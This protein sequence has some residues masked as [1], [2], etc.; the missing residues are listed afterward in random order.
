MPGYVSALFISLRDG[1]A[2]ERE[3]EGRLLGRLLA[4]LWYVI[5]GGA[6]ILLALD[7]WLFWPN[8]IT[9]LP[10]DNVPGTPFA[11]IDI[12]VFPMLFSSGFTALRPVYRTARES[13]RILV[14]AIRSAAAAR[15]AVVAPEVGG[16]EG[17]G[18]ADAAVPGDFEGAATIAPLAHP[19]GSTGAADA[20][21]LIGA[22]A[23]LAWCGGA[24]Y[25]TTTLLSDPYPT[26][27]PQLVSLAELP[28]IVALGGLVLG[29]WSLVAWRE[30]RRARRGMIAEVDG[31]GVTV[32]VAARRGRLRHLRWSDARSFARV[33]YVDNHAQ[34]HIAYIMMTDVG[35][36]LWDEPPA[37]RYLSPVEIARAQALRDAARRLA[38]LVEQRTGLPL[39]DLSAIAQVGRIDPLSAGQPQQ[40]LF[41]QAIEIARGL[42]DRT[43]ARKLWLGTHPGAGE[44]P[45]KE[46]SRI[47]RPG[48]FLR[49][50]TPQR[51]EIVRYALALLPYFPTP[52]QTTPDPLERQRNELRAYRMQRE[53]GILLTAL[54]AI[55]LISA[56]CYGVSHWYMPSQLNPLP[57]RIRAQTPLYIAPFTAHQN[58]WPT[59][60][61]A[62][63]D[64]RSARFTARGYELATTDPEQASAAWTQFT[65]VGDGAVRVTLR[66]HPGDYDSAGM[67]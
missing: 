24:L 48:I 54:L 43:L 35:D 40:N 50:T 29:A 11:L 55:G 62:G 6:M 7:C 58:D 28:A 65:T 64:T 5:V 46:V 57:V 20:L 41:G 36:M 66:L 13:A 12:L 2:L 47:A 23:G 10:G 27:A 18:Q 67:L 39:L 4:A 17:D 22:L 9:G 49:T 56:V 21:Y 14:T 25:F 32:R 3:R 60:S 37:S 44:P 59:R 31:D 33:R 52:E 38:R 8:Y 16:V 1:L 15:D 26:F 19:L 30:A 34:P 45:E 61:P 53:R 42:G 51:D 63:S